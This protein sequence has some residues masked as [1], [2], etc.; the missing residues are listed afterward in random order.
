MCAWYYRSSCCLLAV[1]Y[2]PFS[3]CV[4]HKEGLCP[5]SGDINR[6]MMMIH[7]VPSYNSYLTLT[8]WDRCNIFSSCCDQDS[9]IIF[10]TGLTS[11]LLETKVLTTAN[12]ARTGLTCLPKHGGARWQILI[13]HPMTDLGECCLVSAIARRAHW[14]PASRNLFRVR[15]PYLLLIRSFILL[16]FKLYTF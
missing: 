15:L 13:T 16:W 10:T 3:L 14:P 5:S 9:P 12:A 8:K 4:I 1:G 11:T 2:G 6:L 7:R